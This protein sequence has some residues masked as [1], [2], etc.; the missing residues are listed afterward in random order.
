MNHLESTLMKQHHFNYDIGDDIGNTI[1]RIEK[2]LQEFDNKTILVTGGTGFFGRWLLEALCTLIKEKNINI[3]IY[4][5]SRNPERFLK[6]H[7][8]F[9]FSKYITF[10]AGDVKDFKLSGV[11]LDYLIHMATTAA[12]ETFAGE[13]QLKK[14]DLLYEGTRNTLENAVA[15]G[16]K[17]VLFTSSG[18]VYGPSD[19]ELIKEGCLS[20]PNTTLIS[21]AL[22]EGKRIAEFLVAYYASKA[23]YTYTIARCFSFAGQYLPLDI[24]YA[25]GNFIKDAIYNGKISITGTGKEIRS[26][27]YIGDAISWILKSLVNSNNQIFNIGSSKGITIEDLAIKIRD[28]LKIK[29]NIEIKKINIPE[30]NFARNFYVPST[31]KI[32]TF[33]GVSEWTSLEQIILKMKNH[34]SK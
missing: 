27:L 18:V 17:K 5:V 25:F 7:S 9:P 23:G 11:K 10:I 21:S 1:K 14:I 30:G 24:H 3:T 12:E 2:D 28:Q 22:G 31:E 4:V 32:K 15:A 19:G 34:E 20:A 29:G 33:L 16:V 8:S 13:D 26:Y 6:E